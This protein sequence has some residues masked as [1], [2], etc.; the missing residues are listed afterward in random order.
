MPYA[1]DQFITIENNTD[2]KFLPHG[3]LYRQT[4]N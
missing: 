1:D 4:I 2:E 3:R